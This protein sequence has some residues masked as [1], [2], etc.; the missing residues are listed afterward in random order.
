MITA[1]ITSYYGQCS[2]A[3]HYYCCV[4]IVDDKAPNLHYTGGN[5]DEITRV[6]TD[7]KEAEYLNKKGK[8]RIWR[9]GKTTNRF[10]TI[11]Q[12]HQRLKEL[13]PNEIIVTYYER[14]IFKDMLYFKDNINLGYKYFGEVFSN[15]PTSVY[16]DLL[17]DYSSIIIKC[18]ECGHIYKIEDITTETVY[19]NRACVDFKQKRNMDNPCCK[20]FD[21]QWNVIL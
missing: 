6:I 13:Y 17:P 12:I 19:N 4:Y 11:E 8:C 21:L 14:N 5:H 7:E 1:N 3:E 20:Y 16:K 18:A 15:I 10:S 9:V 2:D